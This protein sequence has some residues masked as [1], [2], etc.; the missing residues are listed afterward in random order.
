MPLSYRGASPTLK[1]WGPTILPTQY[2]T[3][4]QALTTARLVKLRTLLVTND[5]PRGILAA[6]ARLR[7]KPAMRP[8][9]LLAS[10]AYIRAIPVRLIKV[11]I[12]IVIVRIFGSHEQRAELMIT[13]PGCAAPV[14]I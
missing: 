10:R 6:K 1:N 14:G 12:I 13:K 11:S 9:W 5:R 8:A 2:I 4:T 7:Q 3:K